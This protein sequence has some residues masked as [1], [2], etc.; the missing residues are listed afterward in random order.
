LVLAPDAHV[1]SGE[2]QVVIFHG[3]SPLRYVGYL[4]QIATQ[5]LGQFEDVTF[6]QTDRVELLSPTDEKVYIEADGEFV[7]R[8]PAT[9]ETLPEALTLLL[10]PEYVERRPQ[11][12]EAAEVV[13][14]VSRS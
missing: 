7:G 3:D 9:V 12:P 13:S 1:L 11:E 2:F 14:G 6:H 8:L 5:T 4:A 10:P